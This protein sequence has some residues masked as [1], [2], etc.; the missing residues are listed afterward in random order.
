MGGHTLFGPSYCGVTGLLFLEVSLTNWIALRLVIVPEARG[1][2]SSGRVLPL[3]DRVP[4][5][6]P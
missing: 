4:V 2:I 5:R 3:L 6:L 1:K